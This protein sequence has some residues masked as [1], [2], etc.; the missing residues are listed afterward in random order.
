MRGE[1]EEKKGGTK[2]VK[3]VTIFTC[4]GYK[5]ILLARF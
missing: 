4:H 1:R 5:K 2:R 3:G